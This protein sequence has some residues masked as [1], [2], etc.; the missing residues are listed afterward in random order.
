VD[1]EKY[2]MY[3]LRRKKAPGSVMALSPVLKEL[4][5]LKGI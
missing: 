5:G 2:K 4:K 3:S 1:K